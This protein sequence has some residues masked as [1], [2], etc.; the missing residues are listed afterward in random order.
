MMVIATWLMENDD[1]TNVLE[2]DYINIGKWP[3]E[4]I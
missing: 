4:D 3:L 1:D 2:D